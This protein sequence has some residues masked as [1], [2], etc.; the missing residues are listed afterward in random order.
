MAWHL[1]KFFDRLLEMKVHKNRGKYRVYE[2]QTT[3]L[4]ET[5]DRDE[6][7]K[8]W[9]ESHRKK[10]DKYHEVEEWWDGKYNGICQF[11]PGDQ[12]KW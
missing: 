12:V 5:D 1:G 8:V 7:M 4:L 11:K 3:L 10:P 9:R 6:A 2:N